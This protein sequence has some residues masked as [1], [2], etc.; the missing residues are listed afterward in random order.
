MLDCEA[1]RGSC[2][3]ASLGIH[4]R[5]FAQQLVVRAAFSETRLIRQV[6][7]WLSG[8]STLVC[9]TSMLR[10]VRRVTHNGWA[11]GF[12]S[13]L[14][15]AGG[16]PAASRN[17]SRPSSPLGITKRRCRRCGCRCC[18]ALIRGRRSDNRCIDGPSCTNFVGDLGSNCGQRGLS[19]FAIRKWFCPRY[20][21]DFAI[22]DF[23]GTP[24]MMSCLWLTY[25]LR[26][27]G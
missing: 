21:N 16:A 4:R 26:S 22:V 27:D 18:S 1:L 19:T 13:D 11:H 2:T 15:G 8:P 7:S 14:V 24:A 23:A 10:S 3:S 20:S 12:S 9:A 25:S 6:G 17:G 5:S